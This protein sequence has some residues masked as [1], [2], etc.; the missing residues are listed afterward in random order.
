MI[1]LRHA[2]AQNSYLVAARKTISTQRGGVLGKDLPTA[3]LRLREIVRLS[4][5][6]AFATL[7][8]G[9][10]KLFKLQIILGLYSCVS[11]F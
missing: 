5:Y 9:R 1:R 2:D 11:M 8:P 7:A 3:E 6:P 4:G 10:A